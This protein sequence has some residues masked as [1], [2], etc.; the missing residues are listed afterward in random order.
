MIEGPV[1]ARVPASIL[2]HHPNATVVLDTAAAAGLEAREYYEHA[3]RLQ[4]Q[5]EDAGGRI[6]R[7]S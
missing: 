1:T 6:P 7:G 5:L 3:E 4:R 2:Q